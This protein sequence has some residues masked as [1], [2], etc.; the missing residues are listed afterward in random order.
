MKSWKNLF[1]MEMDSLQQ[2]IK[3]KTQYIIDVKEQ[4]NQKENHLEFKPRQVMLDL[5]M[6]KLC[7]PTFHLPFY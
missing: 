1:V 7:Y 5:F 6:G 2:D 4:I 3:L